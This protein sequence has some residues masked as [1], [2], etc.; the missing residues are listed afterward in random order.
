MQEHPSFTVVINTL[1][2]GPELHNTLESLRWLK[3]S[4]EFEVVVVNGPSTDHSD[5]VLSSWG[6]SIRVGK[7]DVANLSVSRNIGICMA[8]GDIVAF[9]DDDA[10]PEPEWLTQLAGA[11]VD[12]MVGAAG[13]LVYDHTGYGFQSKYCLVDRFGNADLS[14][15]Q[16][17]PFLSFPKSTQ[18]PHLLGCN[19]SF[20]RTALLEIGGFDEEFEY[21]LD[22]TDVCLRIVD[23]GYIIAQLP[24]AYV[25]HKFAPSNIRGTSKVPKK[26]FSIIK[27]KFY[28]MLKHA[29]EFYSME[30][31]LT[32]QLKF[33]EDHRNEV[34]WAIGER[35]LAPEDKDV[36]ENDVE[37]AL[38]LGIQRCFTGVTAETL[39]NENK[40]KRY[41]GNFFP[42]PLIDRDKHRVVVLV[43]QDFPPDR[44]GGIATF[45][46]DLAEALAA[47]G[48]IVHVVTKSPDINRVDFEKGVWVHRLLVQERKRPEEILKMEIPQHIWDWSATALKETERI[49]THRAIDVVEAPIWDCE[50]TAFLFNRQWPLLVSLQTTLH[51]WLDSHPEYKNDSEWMRSFGTPMLALEKDI[52][53]NADGV[54]AISHAIRND[55]ERVYDFVFKEKKIFVAPLGMPDIKNRESTKSDADGP[56]SVLYVGRLEYRKGIDVLL[57]AIPALME[58][59]ADLRIRII[60]DDTLP[61]AD[62]KTYKNKFFTRHS[63]ADWLN[64]IQFEGRVYTK[65]LL[66]AYSDC[67]I[68]VAPSR[69]ESFGLVFLEAMRAE[70]PVI[71]CQAGGMPEVVSHNVNGLL[72]E[73]DNVDSL[74]G[75]ILRLVQDE[76]LRN[77]MGMAGRQIFEKKF[78]SKRMAAESASLYSMAEKNFSADIKA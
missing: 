25:H 9:I 34:L 49:S 78:T 48:N 13:G 21:F 20:R 65:T 45:N 26:R 33:I 67:D 57:A 47:E 58:S 8:Q 41:T 55:I 1:N 31:V 38:E 28:F 29:C 60:G 61:T 68:F 10:I 19:A 62:G 46:K 51:Y 14:P 42:F 77:K 71:G 52:M 12:P 74:V 44:G 36:F 37:C 32:E 64:K 72:V 76:E 54:R 43:S 6:R 15:T 2:R 23:A 66:R 53:Q 40:I 4:G 35:L 16:S 7:C 27:N 70:K 24:N 75:A 69:F 18:F 3:Y 59:G 22:E 5:D 30:R 17:Q 39:I 56:L 73:P 63:G 11:Y 50:G